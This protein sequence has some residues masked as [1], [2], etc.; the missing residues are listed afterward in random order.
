MRVEEFITKCF[1]RYQLH[2]WWPG[3]SFEIALSAILVQNTNWKGAWQALSNLREKDLTKYPA[4]LLTIEPKQLEQ[5]IRPAGFYTRKMHAIRSLTNLWIKKDGRPSRE[6]LLSIKGIGEE[7]ADSIILYA[8]NRPTIPIDNYTRRIWMRIPL[9]P[10]NPN[11]SDE[12]RTVLTRT[13]KNDVATLK[14]IHGAFV[15]FG[16]EF[17]L[18]KPRCQSCFLQARCKTG[19]SLDGDGNNERQQ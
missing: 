15:E 18:K 7:T 4:R 13:A 14:K 10:G 6:E 3:T 17:C 16:K 5:L 8:C 2:Q 12:L 19:K 9:H 11:S 1:Q